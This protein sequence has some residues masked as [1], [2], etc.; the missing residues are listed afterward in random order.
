MLWPQLP[1]S[2]RGTAVWDGG[3]G[4]KAYVERRR[5]RSSRIG[6]TIWG[7]RKLGQRVGRRVPQRR[8]CPLECQ[9]Q[10]RR[11]YADPSL[12][13]N[14]TQVY[15]GPDCFEKPVI[16]VNG[17]FPGPAI[18]VNEGD[19]I[20]LTVWNGLFNSA[21]SVH[22]HGIDQVGTPFY[23]GVARVSQDAIEPGDS[24][25]IRT[26]TH[27]GDA[28]TYLYHAHAGML[29]VDGALIV[30]GL[31]ERSQANLGYDEERIILIQDWWHSTPDQDMAGL[32][33]SPT[34][35]WI[36]DAN[37]VL[38]NGK[39]RWTAGACTPVSATNSTLLY[40]TSHEMIPF[41]AGKTYRLR[42]ISAATL[43]YLSLVIP[44]HT[45][46]LIEV[47]ATLVTP[48]NVTKLDIAPGQRFSLIVKADQ[49]P[50]DYWANSAVRWRVSG[51]TN[52]QFL[53]RYSDAPNPIASPLL[54]PN[55]TALPIVPPEQLEYT[56]GLTSISHLVKQPFPATST[57]T[58]I[59]PARQLRDTNGYLRWAV[60]ETIYKLP[61]RPLLLSAY[62]RTLSS[63]PA[64][65]RPIELAYGEVIDVV[66]QGMSGPSGVCEVHPWHL[67]GHS[68]WDLG[69]GEGLYQ[70]G[71]GWNATVPGTPVLRDVVNQYPYVGAYFQ[72]PIAPNA[73]CGW[74][75][76]RFTADNPGV[77]PMHCHIPAHMVMGMMVTFAEAVDKLPKLPRDFPFVRTLDEHI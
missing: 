32:L 57:R 43:S 58:L 73:P 19:I 54:P 42:F 49:Q 45:L 31:G 41:D 12:V 53:I 8:R 50:G 36:G 70:D 14:F 63:V 33:S 69:G 75:K 17:Q 26:Q 38:F 7:P 55:A 62:E 23:D 30:D 72:K 20:E 39:G 16:V 25:T 77:W 48:T 9:G 2:R 22:L 59:L 27:A 44:N 21:L 1:T 67:H 46:T 18:R 24:F 28:G 47:D 10:Q 52:G 51:P 4:V 68:F 15:A 61:S 76:I 29:V 66:L 35:R 6:A 60:N 3:R 13:L 64:A 5:T 65:S 74:K 56:A 40:P 71:M 37:S 11:A 34:F